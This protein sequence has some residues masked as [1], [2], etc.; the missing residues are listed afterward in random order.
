MAARAAVSRS[1]SIATPVEN[2]AELID[3]WEA[4]GEDNTGMSALYTAGKRGNDQ[5]GEQDEGFRVKVGTAD[6]H[7]H[8]CG[9]GGVKSLAAHDWARVDVHMCIATWRYS[10]ISLS[11]FL[12]V[13]SRVGSY[14]ESRVSLAFRSCRLFT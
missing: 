3:K 4:G 14:K 5:A 10:I 1:L 11:E 12:E 13:I 7:E 2:S 6:L 8:F 9:D